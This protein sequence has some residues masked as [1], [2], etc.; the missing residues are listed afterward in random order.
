MSFSKHNSLAFSLPTNSNNFSFFSPSSLRR[1]KFSKSWSKFFRPK[2]GE[3][4]SLIDKVSEST[5]SFSH[6]AIHCKQKVYQSIMWFTRK[7]DRCC[8]L[9]IR[10]SLSFAQHSFTGLPVSICRKLHLRSQQPGQGQHAA[11]HSTA[12]TVCDVQSIKR[13]LQLVVPT[14]QAGWR[15]WSKFLLCFTTN[16]YLC[17]LS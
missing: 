13:F 10:I 5:R 2:N 15:K 1:V 4:W 16:F 14:T 11:L 7:D 6:A 8:S 12:W 3:F 9:S 17:L